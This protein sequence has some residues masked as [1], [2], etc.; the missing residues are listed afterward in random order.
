MMN[1]CPVFAIRYGKPTWP[2]LFF[3]SPR[4]QREAANNIRLAEMQDHPE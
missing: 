2:Q 3:P 1:E 4:V